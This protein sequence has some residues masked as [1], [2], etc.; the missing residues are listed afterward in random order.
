MDER[1][2]LNNEVAR[3][4]GLTPRQVL[5]WTDKGLVVPAREARKAGTMRGYSYANLLEFALAKTL[6]D[7]IGLQVFSAKSILADLREDGMIYLWCSDYSAYVVSFAMK[8]KT[9]GNENYG[10]FS[11]T[12]KEPDFPD[13]VGGTFDWTKDIEKVRTRDLGP[14]KGTLFY[15]SVSPEGKAA[16]EN[17]RIIT[18]WDVIESM[19]RMTRRAEL[20]DEVDDPS[21]WFG[22][23]IVNLG[24]IKTEIDNNINV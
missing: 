5:S 16:K 7:K 18:P 15:I 13:Q 4:V 21:K 17:L 24:G 12:F 2:Y 9:L 8:M 19:K 11:L 10:G 14:H 6:I 1:L 3:I 22:L 20:L 23:T